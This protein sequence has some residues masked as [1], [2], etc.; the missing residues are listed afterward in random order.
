MTYR[1][2]KRFKTK[3]PRVVCTEAVF[4]RRERTGKPDELERNDSSKE[5]RF[6]LGKRSP[7]IFFPRFTGKTEDNSP[8]KRDA[9]R[10]KMFPF[11]VAEQR[12]KSSKTY[13]T[14][15]PFCRLVLPVKISV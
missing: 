5:S 12:G 15:L 11:P 10:L 7:E 6:E 2:K 1:L 14:S 4:G 13:L 9:I 3:L 8:K